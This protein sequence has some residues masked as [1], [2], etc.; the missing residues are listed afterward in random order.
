MEGNSRVTLYVTIWHVSEG[1]NRTQE[2]TQKSL[3]LCSSFELDVSCTKLYE[4]AF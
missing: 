4:Y 1:K 2:A 3:C